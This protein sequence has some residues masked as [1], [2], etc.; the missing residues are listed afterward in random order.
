MFARSLSIA[1]LVVIGFAAGGCSK[2]DR[3][4]TCEQVTDHLLE[5]MKAPA[6]HEGMNLGNRKQMLESCEK[7]DPS[8]ETRLC[9]MAAKD[10]T[11]MANCAPPPSVKSGTPAP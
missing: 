6:G 4:P 1:L 8:K 7:K 2:A 10:M 5:L 11:A 9:L 3:G